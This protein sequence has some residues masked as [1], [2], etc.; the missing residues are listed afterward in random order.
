[1]SN[2]RNIRI[3]TIGILLVLAALAWVYFDYP[4]NRERLIEA[5]HKIEVGVV[6]FKEK[7]YREALEIFEN[8]PPGSPRE[9]YARYYQGSTHIMLKDYPSAVT[10]LDQALALNPTDTKIMHAL[11]VAYYKMGKLEISKAYYAAILEID[12]D[13]G[14]ARGLMDIMTNLEHMQPDVNQSDST[15]IERDR[16]SDD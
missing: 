8:I 9:W 2:S 10:Y 5:D 4:G 15:T 14:E 7:K 3:W 1:M 12:P 16:S 11:G 6:L 13:D